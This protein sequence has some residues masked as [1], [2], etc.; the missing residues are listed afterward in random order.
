MKYT[1]EYPALLVF[2]SVAC[3]RKVSPNAIF[4]S[5]SQLYVLKPATREP[6]PGLLASP[7]AA[8]AVVVA[9]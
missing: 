8:A 5:D 2:P 9:C 4:S 3:K 6:A 1:R 7:P